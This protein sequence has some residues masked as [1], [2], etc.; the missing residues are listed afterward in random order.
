L[1]VRRLGHDGIPARRNES[2]A[3]AGRDNAEPRKKT[4][5]S[6]TL[7]VNEMSRAILPRDVSLLFCAR[8]SGALALEMK[9]NHKPAPFARPCVRVRMPG[10]RGPLCGFVFR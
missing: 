7:Y 2:G 8:A 3:G 10:W 1:L 4:N 5:D 6:P 9:F